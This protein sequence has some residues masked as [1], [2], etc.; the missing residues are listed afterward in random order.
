MNRDNAE[1]ALQTIDNIIFY[2][3]QKIIEL[4]KSVF[5]YS[6]MN[7]CIHSQGVGNLIPKVNEDTK[8]CWHI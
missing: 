2:L 4:A 7:K 3:N 6:Y 5:M 8:E 1:N